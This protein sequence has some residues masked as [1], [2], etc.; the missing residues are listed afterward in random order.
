MYISGLF[1][2][3]V[4]VGYPTAEGRVGD[5]S[6]SDICTETRECLLSDLICGNEKYQVRH[7]SPVKWVSTDVENFFMEVP[8]M[9]AFRR[10]F[11]YIS[12]ANDKN[13]TIEMTSPVLVK[14]QTKGI[15][16]MAVYTM[17]FLL[18]T[19]HQ[20]TPPKPNNP[21]VYI[22]DM[23]EKNVYVQSYGEYMMTHTDRDQARDLSKFLDKIGA[24][25]NKDFHMAAGYN[26]PMTAKNR[27]NEVWYVVEGEPVC[28]DNWKPTAP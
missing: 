4:A 14:V 13:Q 15:F 21:E 6:E 8:A 1:L 5:S 3:M 18:P 19:E 22:Y 12:G 9:I 24:Q 25:Y 23:P 28:P 2:A 11:Q 17:S 26:S 7:Y 27:H 16:E 20:M 10:L